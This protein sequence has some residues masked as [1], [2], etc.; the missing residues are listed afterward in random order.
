MGPLALDSEGDSS[1]HPDP[2]RAPAVQ[3]FV[4]RV[5]DVQPDFRL[6]AANGPT[7]TEIC[8]RLDALP[9]ALELAAP[10]MKVLT[11]EELLRR[12][13]RDVLLSTAGPRDLPERQQTINA[14][15]AWSHQLLAPNEQ[16]IFRRL[17][18]LPGR[19]PIE[20][21]A[22]VVTGREDSSSG[23]DKA[24]RAAS[25]LIDKSLLL[26]SETSAT[27]RPLYLHARNRAGICGP[28]ARGCG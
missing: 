16:R 15:V 12:L 2:A 6:T 14:T 21:V 24:L 9:L 18:I 28:R 13:T 11:A 27:T 4:E 22:A 19:F 20:A 3:L 26:R 25:S 7:V 10:W 5:R 17:G 1:S 23:T 8:R